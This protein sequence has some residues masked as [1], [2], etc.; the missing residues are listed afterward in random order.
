[1]LPGARARFEEQGDADVGVS[2]EGARYRLNIARQQGQLS[3]VA[4]A[5]PSGALRFVDLR[6]PEALGGLAMRKRGLVLVTGAT[7][8][9]KS[10]TLAAMLHYINSNRRAHVVTIEDP[11]EFVHKDRKSRITQRE[12]GSDTA[13]FH[14]ALRHVV[15][16]SPDVI[17]IGELR[18]RETIQVALSAALTG[19]LVLAS[20]HTIDATQTLQR[21]LSY[22]PEHLRAQAS[23][24]LSLSLQGIVSQ[25]LLPRADGKGR[26]LITEL[27]TASPATAQLL[28]EQRGRGPPGHDARQPLRGRPHLQHLA[29]IGLAGAAH[30]PRG[31]PGL[32]LQSRRIRPDGAGHGHRRGHL[33]GQARRP[34][35]RRRRT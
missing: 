19:H 18:D 11:I 33:P 8:S 2:L 27:L 17:L 6:L 5:L 14:A 12:V 32:L 10:T 13:S 24:D 1:M 4:R 26:V 30:H 20:L 29:H 28:R 16:Q 35:S 34:C 31:G 23:M 3:V 25:R 22:Y 15:R 21:L 7:G 9:G